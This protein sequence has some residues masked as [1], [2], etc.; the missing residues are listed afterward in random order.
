MFV[1]S[2]AF[3]AMMTGEGDAEQLTAR[4]EQARKPVTSSI[5]AFETVLALSRI[6]GIPKELAQVL[7]LEFVKAAGVEMVS[8]GPE[9]HLLALNAHELYGKG[10]GHPAQLNMGDCF[11]YAMAKSTSG[12]LLYK[13]SDFRHT[14]LG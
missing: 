3:V 11:S 4:L 1:D 10:T 14:D 5:V 8:I 13:G 7:F 9:M 2:S 12:E 6:Y